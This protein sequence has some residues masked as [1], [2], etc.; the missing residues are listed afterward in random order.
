MMTEGVVIGH[1]VSKDG[2]KVDPTKIQVVLKFPTPHTQTEVHSF[3]G[4]AGYCRRFIES[5]SRIVAPLHDLI[6]NVGFQWCDKCDIAFAQLKCDKLPFNISL[7]TSYV[8]IGTFLGQE[9]DKKPYVIY[10]I[11][12]NI[13]PANLNYTVTKKQFVDLIHAINKF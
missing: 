12:K 4:C 7:G 3:L 8:S 1:Y 13:T 11:S 5:F 10:F 9:E 2:I 6:G